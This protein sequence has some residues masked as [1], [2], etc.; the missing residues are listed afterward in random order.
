MALVLLLLA[1][2]SCRSSDD[3]SR[4]PSA[5]AI[6]GNIAFCFVPW[7]L[8]SNFPLP[9]LLALINCPIFEWWRF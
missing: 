5:A 8:R 6:A 3:L 1:D 4:L 9:F 2:L 7:E